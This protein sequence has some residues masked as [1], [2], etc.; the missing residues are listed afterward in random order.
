MPARLVLYLWCR[1]QDSDFLYLTGIDQQAV[2]VI[3]AS[4]PIRDSTFTLYLA[5]TDSQ[6]QPCFHALHHA[7]SEHHDCQ[8]TA[9]K[10]MHPDK[11][12]APRQ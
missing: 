4:S 5:D 12:K 7:Q 8:T 1:V 10:T 3:E 9:K 11:G 2:A 6:V